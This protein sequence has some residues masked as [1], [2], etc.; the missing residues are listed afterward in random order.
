M[1]R[2]ENE[3]VH[4]NVAVLR[5]V[6]SSAPRVRELPSGA[7]L[8]HLEVTTRIDGGAT[9][10]PVVVS[11]PDAIVAALD[12]GDEVVVVG[13]VARRYF[14]AGGVTQSRTELVADRVTRASRRQAVERAL[15]A[16][17]AALLD[18]SGVGV[19]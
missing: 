13:R 14:R 19:G 16:A 12:A 3:A 1:S 2:P 17:R 5:G 6:L 9:S 8:V 7:S 18:G 4:V 11:A 15:N 10:V